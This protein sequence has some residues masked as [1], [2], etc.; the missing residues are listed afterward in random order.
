M[1]K[2]HRKVKALTPR[3]HRTPCSASQ[4]EGAQPHS[5]VNDLIQHLR[6]TQPPTEQP[7]ADTVARVMSGSVHPTIRNILDLPVTRPPRPRFRLGPAVGTRRPWQTPGP[8]APT[9]WLTS[10]SRVGPGIIS[11]NGAPNGQ[12]ERRLNH[13]PGLKFPPKH[14]FQHAILKAMARNWDWHVLYDGEY[15]SALPTYT[16]Q[17]LLSYIA[18]Y[19]ENT[20]L[21]FNMR[22]LK[23]LFLDMTADGDV[24]I[25]SDVTRLDLGGALGRWIN[26]KTLQRE[27]RSDA[28]LS[29]D[30]GRA[31]PISW[32]EEA[33]GETS[34]STPSF[35]YEEP[36]ILRFH[37]LRY[38][39]LA[40]PSPPTANWQSLLNLLSHVSTLTHLSLAHWPT[41]TLAANSTVS[42]APSMN[43][44]QRLPASTNEMLEATTVLGKLSRASYCLQ[45]LDL[46]GCGEW[47][48]ALCWGCSDYHPSEPSDDEPPLIPRP[49]GPEWNG[50][51]RGIEWLGLGFGWALEAVELEGKQLT[52][53]PHWQEKMW[54]M[55]MNAVNYVTTSIQRLRTDAK[56]KWI[57]VCFEHE[58]PVFHELD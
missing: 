23:P 35:I 37:N 39:S 26:L 40:R 8:A 11:R 9:S 46:N 18:V 32:E 17:L 50:S 20:S 33:W 21:A 56:G 14:S 6:R 44:L 42:G 27:L 2:K 30:G 10:T 49:L 12:L 36:V 3:I 47:L 31:I 57:E 38:L 54:N 45:W 55:H 28:S 29:K 58:D 4:D 1:P 19:T 43:L 48:P 34:L 7:R 22:G 5:S 15:L 16:K 51:W 13:L 25:H 52:R 41:P 53:R 24:A